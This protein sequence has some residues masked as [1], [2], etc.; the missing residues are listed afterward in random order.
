MISFIVIGRNEGWKLT[1]CLESVFQTIK[2][3]ALSKYEVIYVDSKSTDDSI[4]RA[5]RFEETKIFQLTGDF[6]AAIARNIAANNS[7]GEILFFLDGNIELKPFNFQIITDD[8]YQLKY[9]YLVGFLD[10]V[11]YTSDWKYINQTPRSYKTDIKDQQVTTVGGEVYNASVAREGNLGFES[12]YMLTPWVETLVRFGLVLMIP[13]TIILLRLIQYVKK[14]SR[15]DYYLVLISFFIYYI[16]YTNAIY[17]TFVLYAIL[18][19][20]I[21]VVKHKRLKTDKAN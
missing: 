7:S 1:K 9:N 19:L 8:Y 18:W 13:F 5:K 15:K 3:N 20:I 6:N 12:K 4:V 11:N 17:K 2:Q 21:F 10:D 16:F 14:D